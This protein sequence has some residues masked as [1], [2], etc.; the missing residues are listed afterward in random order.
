MQCLG[1][2]V[3]TI[4]FTLRMPR[5][6]LDDLLLELNCWKLLT[7]YCLKELRSLLGNLSFFTA[8]V[9]SQLLYNLRSFPSTQRTTSITQDMKLDF[10]W[11]F[12]FLP[13]FR[14]V[15]NIKP[16]IWTFD[17]FH[18]TTDSCL[19]GSGATCADQCLHFTIPPVISYIY[20]VI[21]SRT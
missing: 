19:H 2:E 11:C 15:S 12:T 14:G 3:D 7:L 13:L 16:G 20:D 18:F 21:K 5:D 10:D 1:I 8:C 6:R 17:D 4:T 9:M